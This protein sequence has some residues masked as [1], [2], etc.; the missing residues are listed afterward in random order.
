MQKQTNLTLLLKNMHQEY[1]TYAVY[2][3]CNN[4][5][6]RSLDLNV[7]NACW[8]EEIHRDCSL[9]ANINFLL[10]KVN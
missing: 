1:L 8:I 2:I 7:S 4:I 5:L 6:T 10:F 9:K 3:V